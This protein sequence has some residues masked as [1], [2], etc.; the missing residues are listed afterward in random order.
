MLK[1]VKGVK[2]TWNE[3][4]GSKITVEQAQ[5][6]DWGVTLSVNG[7]PVSKEDANVHFLYS[8]VTSK[9]KPYSSTTVP[10]TEPGRYVVTVVTLG[11]DY[12]A[13]P[14]TRSFRIVK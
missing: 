3:Q 13:A 6:M 14:I 10:P 12:L 1:N 2:L 7:E 5:S 9:W 4:I 11:G 8:G